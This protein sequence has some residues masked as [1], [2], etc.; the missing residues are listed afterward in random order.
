M[1][2]E[3]RTA[4]EGVLGRKL[5]DK[6]ADLLEQAFIKASKELPQEDI[7]AWKSMSDEERAEAIADRAVKNYTDQHMKEVTNLVNDLEIREAL[8]LELTSHSKLNPLEALNRKL[9]MHTD[10]SGIQ[11]VEHNIQAIET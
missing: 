1:K 7:K 9:V 5:T 10:Q 6:E 4:V 3:C 2:N 11:S 8:E